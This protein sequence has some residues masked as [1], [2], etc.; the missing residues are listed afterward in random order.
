M[1][2]NPTN[3]NDGEDPLENGIVFIVVVLSSIGILGPHILGDLGLA[4]ALT[5]NGL[6]IVALLGLMAAY[7]RYDPEDIIR[8]LKSML[9]KPAAWRRNWRI[10]DEN[11]FQVTPLTTFMKLLRTLAAWLQTGVVTAWQWLSAVIAE[12]RT[13]DQSDEPTDRKNDE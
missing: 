12:Y 3:N 5:L 7:R 1:A 10:R 11:P 2:H 8:F 6:T 4:V 13:D 9:S